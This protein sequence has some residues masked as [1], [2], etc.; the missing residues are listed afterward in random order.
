MGE[1]LERALFVIILV[2]GF[3]LNLHVAELIG[4]EDFTA[5][6]TLHVFGIVFARDYSHL[7]MFAGR[8]H[9]GLIWA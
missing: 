2:F 6:L 7:G 1:R 8:I 3:F 4:I 5:L 9:W